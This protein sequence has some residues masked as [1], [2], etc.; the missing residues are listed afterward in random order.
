MTAEFVPLNQYRWVVH[1]VA[2]LGWVIYAI[3]VGSLV[4]LHNFSGFWAWLSVITAVV[5]NSAHII[6][7][8]LSQQGV[9]IKNP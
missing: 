8:G 4:I 2:T 3:V 5:G 9:S 1:L 6:A 7:F